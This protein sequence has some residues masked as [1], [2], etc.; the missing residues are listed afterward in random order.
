MDPK[1][2]PIG[3]QETIHC[4]RRACC[5]EDHDGRDEHDC[6]NRPEMPDDDGW[7]DASGGVEGDI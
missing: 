5:G 4:L 1:T 7:G 6:P 2:R 3:A